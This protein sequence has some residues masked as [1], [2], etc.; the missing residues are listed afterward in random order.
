MSSARATPGSC[1]CPPTRRR[2]PRSRASRRSPTG[3]PGCGSLADEAGPQLVAAVGERGLVVQATA[4]AGGHHVEVADVGERA[5]TVGDEPVA[6]GEGETRPLREVL[7]GRRPAV[8]GGTPVRQD[9]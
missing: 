7:L 8:I 5:L 1:R 6:G 9:G 3:C 2:T 4:L